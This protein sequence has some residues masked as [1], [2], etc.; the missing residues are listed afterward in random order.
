MTLTSAS[1]HG[2]GHRDAD[3]G[4]GGE[5]EHDL[6]LAAGDQVDE[7]GRRGCRAWWKLKSWPASARASARLASEPGRQVVDDVDRVAL[8]QQAVDEGASR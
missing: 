1:K 7:L 5:V 8:G 3:V 2:P 6:G 4:L